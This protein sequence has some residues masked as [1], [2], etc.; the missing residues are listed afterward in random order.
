MGLSLST[1][2][3]LL[4]QFS[5]CVLLGCGAWVLCYFG[6]GIGRYGCCF[7]SRSAPQI[8][9]RSHIDCSICRGLVW[10]SKSLRGRVLFIRS[11]LVSFSVPTLPFFPSRP[12]FFT[13]S[14][15]LP[16]PLGL[17]CDAIRGP[18]GSGRRGLPSTATIP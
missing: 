13:M 3:R 18:S 1:R 6:G 2:R 9:I 5:L 10:R 4:V 16:L 14:F 17:R 15:K 12:S 7:M 11:V 8:A